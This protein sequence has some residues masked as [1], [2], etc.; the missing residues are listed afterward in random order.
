M[1]ENTVV[2]GR[3]SLGIQGEQNARKISFDDAKIWQERFGQGRYELL[4]QRNGDEAPYPVVLTIEDDVP[5]WYVTSSDTA[6]V[7]EGQCELRYIVDDVLIKSSTYITDVAPSLGENTTDVPEPEKAWVDQVLEAGETAK[8]A[9]ELSEKAIEASENAEQS[10]KDAESFAKEAE[11]FASESGG[12]ISDESN[13]HNVTAE[14]VGAYNKTE[15]DNKLKN[16]FYEEQIKLTEV[17]TAVPDWEYS[18]VYIT[19]NSVSS[20]G[21]RYNIDIKGNVKFKCNIYGGEAD[22]YID[23]KNVAQLDS[24]T[25]NTEYTFDGVINES[26]SV[27]CAM[28]NVTFAEFVKKV[29]V[30]DVLSDIDTALDSILAIQESIVGGVEL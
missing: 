4:H 7:G 26:M 28:T 17:T 24:Y 18:S 13:P 27:Y 30:A 10:A 3:I 5:Y 21:C 11:N 16:P 22:I 6:V 9:V 20:D 8:Q 14:Q 2:C 19:D 23:G 25:D 12:H 1:F 15:V 29:Y